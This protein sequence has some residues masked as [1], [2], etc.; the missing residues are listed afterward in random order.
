MAAELV[1]KKADV[2]DYSSPVSAIPDSPVI[3]VLL[4]YM[5]AAKVQIP[6]AL[7]PTFIV[8]DAEGQRMRTVRYNIKMHPVFDRIIFRT[9]VHSFV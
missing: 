1:V 6:A 9:R 4:P 7:K 5:K 3:P 8:A 2:T